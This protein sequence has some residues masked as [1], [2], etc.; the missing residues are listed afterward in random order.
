MGFIP[1]VEDNSIM[2]GLKGISRIGD[3]IINEII[4]NRPYNSLQDFLNKMV[5]DGKT[6]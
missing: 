1:D 5:V 6:Y 4:S 2:F 3:D